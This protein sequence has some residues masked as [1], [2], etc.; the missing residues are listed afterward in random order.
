[1]EMR[2][3]NI[4]VSKEIFHLLDN[5]FNVLFLCKEYGKKK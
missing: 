5:K 3:A 4:K 2:D 1:M